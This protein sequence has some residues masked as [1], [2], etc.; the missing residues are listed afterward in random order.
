MVAERQED[1]RSYQRALRVVG[2]YLD[3]EPSYHLSVTETA[4]GLAVRAHSN[5]NGTDERV[6]HFEWDRLEDMDQFYSAANRG[7][8]SKAPKVL[9]EQFPCGHQTAL[10]KLGAI[11]DSEGAS[12]LSINEAAGGLDVSFLTPASDGGRQ[13]QVRSF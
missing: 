4:D 10:R 3:S 6:K 13:K 9:W 2:R 8:G 1:H 5:P 12:D 11:L 7:L